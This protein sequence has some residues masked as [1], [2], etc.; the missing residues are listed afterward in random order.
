MKVK[1]RAHILK[2]WEENRAVTL[3]V[4]IFEVQLAPEMED[5]SLLNWTWPADEDIIFNPHSNTLNR[6]INRTNEPMILLRE[7]NA[8][9][10]GSLRHKQKRTDVML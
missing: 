4:W 2:R 9:L 3:P 1:P 5:Q 7:T 8:A 10:P 6:P